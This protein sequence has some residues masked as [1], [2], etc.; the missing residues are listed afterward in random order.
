[1]PAPAAPAAPVVVL[2]AAS[3]QALMPET[4]LSA[5]TDKWVRLGGG[6]RGAES[7]AGPGATLLPIVAIRWRGFK[8][9]RRRASSGAPVRFGK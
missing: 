3:S 4:R 7:G 9:A 1:V 2:A 6:R 8:I 5:S